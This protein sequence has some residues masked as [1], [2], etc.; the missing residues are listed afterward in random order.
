MSPMPSSF[1]LYPTIE[2]I[3]RRRI[4]DLN[5]SL[6]KLHK[7]TKK[8]SKHMQ[9]LTQRKK[10]MH[11]TSDYFLHDSV[12]SVPWLYIVH[13]TT[14]H[15]AL[16]VLFF[17]FLFL[18][19]VCMCVVR[20]CLFPFGCHGVLFFS[21]KIPFLFIRFWMQYLLPSAISNFTCSI[22]WLIYLL[23]ITMLKFTERISRHSWLILQVKNDKRQA[24]TSETTDYKLLSASHVKIVNVGA[25][26]LHQ[27]TNC[28]H[29]ICLFLNTHTPARTRTLWTLS[30]RLIIS[31]FS[32]QI[33]SM[34]DLRHYSIYIAEANVWI[35]CTPVKFQFELAE[36][37]QMNS[38]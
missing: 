19:F 28:V 20:H 1:T 3:D 22:P 7:K 37:P 4:N 18:Y 26:P 32:T 25:F 5:M 38:V 36:L 27:L 17:F 14:L 30:D 11:R 10:I 34:R 24:E 13:W 35:D 21:S 12:F 6:F 31:S 9:I 29:I 15:C 2:R 23:F 8:N 33:V 16:T